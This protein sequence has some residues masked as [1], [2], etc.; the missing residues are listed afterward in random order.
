M[1]T[2]YFDESYNKR[3]FCVGG[4]L[5]SDAEW[6][7]TSRQ[8]RKEIRRTNR[9]SIKAGLRPITRFHASDCA[10]FGRDF[11]GWNQKRQVALMQR[12][13][14]II[15]TNKPVGFVVSARLGDFVR[16][17]P[18]HED[19]RHMGCYFFCMLN[20]FLLIGDWMNK[21]LPSERVAIIY[22]RGKISE[23]GAPKAF[24]SMKEDKGWE[25]R[26]FFA[27][28][29]PMGWE[30]C[31]PLE[32]SDLLAYEGFKLTINA[33]L[34]SAEIRRSLQSMLGAGVQIYVQS[35]MPDAFEKLSAVQKIMAGAQTNPTLDLRRIMTLAQTALAHGWLPTRKK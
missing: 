20:C 2:A 16:G 19:E 30:Q 25:Y 17:Y 33:K 14:G 22:D 26:R 23:T 1:L 15:S 27:T 31:T 8:W 35:Y 7:D 18:G 13:T 4:W 10:T 3:C 11:R 6:S 28:I 32:T 9:L 21:Y 5:A 34:G 12:L 24:R 29:A